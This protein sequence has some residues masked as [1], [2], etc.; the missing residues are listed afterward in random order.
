MNWTV[1]DYAVGAQAFTW[2]ADL[3]HMTFAGESDGELVSAILGTV[4][5]HR[6]TMFGWSNDETAQTVLSSRHGVNFVGAD[7]P[8]PAC[9][10]PDGAQRHP[11]ERSARPVASTAPVKE[12]RRVRDG[13][14]HR[15]RQHRGAHQPSRGAVGDP[16]R[17]KVPV[18]WSMQ[19]MAPSWTPGIARHYFETSS[20]NDEMVALARLWVSRLAVF[21]RQP[22]L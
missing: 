18:G 11:H 6:A 15:R 2:T 9:C 12:G 17:G 13:G 3:R 10:E 14:L 20:F 8:G 5:R 21:R 22:P 7:T 1:R 19:G 4:G 16:E